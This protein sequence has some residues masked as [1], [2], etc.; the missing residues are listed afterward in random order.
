MFLATDA[1]LNLYINIASGL[2]VNKKIIEKN[3]M[4]E[5]PFMATEKIL[6]EAVLKGG[7]RQEL[8]EA[9]RVYSLKAAEE[10]KM[11]KKI[12]CLIIYKM[13][14]DLNFPKKKLKN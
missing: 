1:I 13:T 2:K 12:G 8:H 4:K 11:E 10:V 6:M 3:V 7:D 9:I 5:L 14:K